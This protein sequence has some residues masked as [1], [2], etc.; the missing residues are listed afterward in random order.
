ML[1]EPLWRPPAPKGFSDDERRLGRRLG[2]AARYR[3]RLCAARWRTGVDPQALLDTALGP[4]AS[5]ETRQTVR[6]RRE[7]RAG[8]GAA[9]DGAG[10]PAEVTMALNLHAPS[11]RELLLGLRRAV[12]LGAS[13]E[14][15]ARRR[16]R[17]A[18]ADDRAA[19]R[20]RWARRGGAGR[21]SGLGQAARRQGAACSTARRRRCRSIRSSR[22][23][24]RCRTCIGSTRP[25]RRPS[26]TR[27]RRPIA[28]ARISTARTCSK[29]A[30]GKPGAARHR[31]AQPRARRA[32]AGR[33]RQP[34]RRQGLRG[35]SGDAAGG[36]RTGAGAVMG[37]AAPAAGERRHHD[38][39]ARSLPPHRSGAGARAGGAHRARRMARAGGMEP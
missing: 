10:I 16:P 27:R 29:A 7:P 28:S 20:A 11:R 26:C 35:R 15:R 17:S 1:G 14:A 24:R 12:R 38:A 31:L 39:A 37:A 19:R 25:G 5:A 23:I 3:Q 33:A 21:R 9:V 34:E 32:R 2:A 8:V 6:P 22:S 30:L 36:A 4:L 13:A 18:P